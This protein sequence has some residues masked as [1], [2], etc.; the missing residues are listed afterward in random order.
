MLI[1]EPSDDGSDDGEILEFT[2]Y[3]RRHINRILRYHN[4]FKSE[5]KK[6]FLYGR[7]QACKYTPTELKLTTSH[8]SLPGPFESWRMEAV[9]GKSAQ[10]C[11]LIPFP[12]EILQNALDFEKARLVE[13][14]FSINYGSDENGVARMKTMFSCGKTIPFKQLASVRMFPAIPG[15]DSIVMLDKECFGHVN[16]KEGTMLMFSLEDNQAAMWHVDLRGSIKDD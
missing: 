7:T 10:E 14:I 16:T 4:E 3:I 11:Y 1:V 5:T 2:S 9:H 12:E 8:Q 13:F 6:V 15:K